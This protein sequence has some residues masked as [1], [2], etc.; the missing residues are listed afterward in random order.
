MFEIMAPE[1]LSTGLAFELLPGWWLGISTSFP[2]AH[3]LTI[4]GI[5]KEREWSPCVP[6]AD[7]HDVLTWTGFSGVDFK[8]NDY[9][10]TSCHEMSLVVSTAAS[11]YSLIQ[12]PAPVRKVNVV[13]DTSSPAQINLALEIQARF[14]SSNQGK[15]STIT[16]REAESSNENFMV[17]YLELEG[18]FLYDIKEE[19]FNLLRTSLL[20][21]SNT[22]DHASWWQWSFASW[23][24]NLRWPG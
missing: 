16:L 14:D 8:F 9:Q 3:L 20:C 22:M 19:S 10:E 5:E 21:L 6:E 15:F 7:W 24:W 1:I 4:L 13:I 18:P 12:D 11:E 23:V 17:F 2:R